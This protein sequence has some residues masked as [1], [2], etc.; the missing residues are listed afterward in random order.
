M[1]RVHAL[2]FVA[3]LKYGMGA[4]V[5]MA[6]LVLGVVVPMQVQAASEVFTGGSSVS[7][8]T[9]TPTP[10]TDLQVSGT[11]NDTISISLYVPSTG[12][13]EM[14]NTTGLTFT[15]GPTGNSLRFSGTRSDINAALATLQ[16]STGLAGTVTLEASLLGDGAVYYPANGHVYQ[17]V[18]SDCEG[19]SVC[20]SWDD[21]ATAAGASTY[22]GLTGYLATITSAEENQYIATRLTG[23]AAWIGSSDVA[24]EGDW[25]WMGG[26]ENGVHFWTGDGNTGANEPG[27]YSNWNPG[28][29]NDSS[30]EDCGEMYAGD[31]SGMWNDLP[32]SDAILGSYI[33]EYGD[34]ET[35]AVET[36]NVT[37]T[38]SLPTGSTETISSCQELLAID[39][40]VDNQWNHYTLT[41]DL[42]CSEIE[43]FTPIGNDDNFGGATFNGVFDGQNHTISGLHIEAGTDHAG[44]FAMTQLATIRNLKLENG[45]VQTTGRAGSLI[46]YAEDTDIVNVSS[47]FT[48]SGDEAAG[49]IVGFVQSTDDPNSPHDVAFTGLVFNGSV[50]STGPV[51]GIVGQYIVYPGHTVEITKS[52]TNGS[53]Q[54]TSSFAGGIVGY[55]YVQAT[56]SDNQDDATFVVANSYSRSFVNADVD[57]SGGIIGFAQAINDGYDNQVTIAVERS[58]SSGATVA[59][60]DGAGGIL[61][62]NSFLNNAGEIIS[63]LHSFAAGSVTANTRAFALIGG[64]QN[65]SNGE[66]VLTGNYI[67]ETT[68]GHEDDVQSLTTSTVSVNTDGTDAEYFMNNTTSQPLDNW[69]FSTI[70]LKH[71]HD[72]PTLL[73]SSDLSDLN[74]D[75]VLDMDQP[76]V[77]GYTSAYTGKTVALDVGEGCE[78]TVDD[79]V[80][81]ADLDVTDPAYSYDN[82]LFAFS[83]DCVT[84]GATT[85]IKLYYY[86]VSK[87]GLVIR[88][89]NPNT[90]A[91][92]NLT[93]AHGASLTERTIDGQNV[94]V[95]TYQ[96]TDNGILDMDGLLDGNIDD[97][98]GLGSSTLGVPNTGIHRI[99]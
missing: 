54:T 20:I 48:V 21:A 52:Y 23:G 10:I 96:V 71:L 58:Y 6:Y 89:Y 65:I 76:N 47:D 39:D 25:K 43:N 67:D 73:D 42:D 55:V 57:Y 62:S 13:L 66:L 74:G 41:Q 91:Y 83:A 64:E 85:T 11:G 93:D 26:P 86:G 60:G 19:N 36:K 82:G 44:L 56:S 1:T 38:T 97:P 53:V 4:M 80:R 70:W 12:N 3:K 37:I 72:F 32:C 2:Y 22:Q 14:T 15:V 78:L 46:G 28:E 50:S 16:F 31:S 35:P 94:T 68:T 69:N 88:K 40:T 87:E 81:E 24:N 90:N 27:Q 33:I 34:E 51:G 30:G 59:G 98:V 18:S 8:D 84:P 79:M 99:K 63:I 75:D 5:L 9:N 95:A 61:G 29:P 49:G 7:G 45:S 77:G 17:V 92:F